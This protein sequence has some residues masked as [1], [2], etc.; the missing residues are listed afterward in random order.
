[1]GTNQPEWDFGQQGW[2]LAVCDQ[3]PVP[4]GNAA[5]QPCLVH[6]KLTLPSPNR[7][8]KRITVHL[9][10]PQWWWIQGLSRDRTGDLRLNASIHPGDMKVGSL[11]QNSYLALPSL[12]W[13]YKTHGKRTHDNF[14]L[15]STESPGREWHAVSI[16]GGNMLET[17]D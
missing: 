1:M 17:Y 11:W 10:P 13:L 7:S 5:F 16:D 14:T 8:L 4:D 2:I 9:S 3:H 12:D 15:S 6:F